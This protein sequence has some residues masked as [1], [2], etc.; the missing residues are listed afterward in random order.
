[1]AVAGTE[2]VILDTLMRYLAGLTFSPEMKVAQPGVAFSPRIN[3]PYLRAAFLPNTSRLDGLAFDSDRTH[4]GL[5]VVTVVWPAGQGFVKPMEVAAQ[6]RRAFTAGTRI[7]GIGL[8]VAI[9]EEPQTAGV[10]DDPP[11]IG[12][13]VT[14][15]WRVGTAAYA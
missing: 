4:V 11:W 6:V 9:D 15:R 7:E 10:V 1:M 14:V 13:P 2:A 5:F 3:T 8:T 12:V